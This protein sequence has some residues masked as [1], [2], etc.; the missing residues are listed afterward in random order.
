MD[1]RLL[2]PLEVMD[3]SGNS[4]PINRKKHRQLLAALL[5]RANTAVPCVQL[6][7]NVWGDDPPRSA[8]GNLKTY[9]SQLRQRIDRIETS[10][11]GYRIRVGEHELDSAVFA[12]MLRRG[13]RTLEEGR[14]AEAARTLE[15]ALGLWRG[16]TLQDTPLDGDLALTHTHLDEQRLTCFETLMD[17]HLSQGRHTEVLARLYPVIGSHPL[18]ERLWGLQMTALYR[19]GRC[20]EALAAYRTMRARLVEELGV[21]PS[22]ELERLHGQILARD[23]ALSSPA[24]LPLRPASRRPAPRAQVDAPVT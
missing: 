4:I 12:A 10:G 17:I 21:D 22:P 11:E 6:I 19:D 20:A 8:R 1:F 3:D 13:L 14:P 2:G 15:E 9:V 5:V 24:D 18:H 7:N 23:P 16:A